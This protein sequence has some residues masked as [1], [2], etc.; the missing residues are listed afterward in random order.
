MIDAAATPLVSVGITTYNRPAYLKQALDGVLSQTYSNLEIIVSEDSTPCEETK[1]L[2]LEYSRRDR[3]IRY[4]SQSSNLGPPA[5]LQFVLGQA[6][7]E[8]FFWADD[9][10]LRDQRWVEV[11]LRKLANEDAVVA[12]SN[13]VAID[14]DGNPIRSYRPLR[15]AG[16][17]ITRLARYFLADAA[18][19]KVNLVYGIFRTAF[20]REIK[21]WGRYDHSLLA[22]DSLFMLDCLRRGNAL[23]DPSVTLY[24]RVWA[25][26]SVPVSSIGDL[27]RRVYKELRQN[28]AYIGVIDRWPD[29]A[30]LFLLIPVKLTRMLLY[31]FA[32]RA[33]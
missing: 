17:R 10:D 23:V 29:K 14:P 32:R 26:K 33:R 9:D 8:Y 31:R 5:N 22:V 1:A 4:I 12:F 7:G 24:K 19:G 20:L 11:L 15:F 3:R 30:M 18:E 25:S 27:F 6:S 2:L 13:L 16:A 21:H 28:L